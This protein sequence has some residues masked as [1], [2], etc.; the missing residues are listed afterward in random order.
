MLVRVKVALRRNEDRTEFNQVKTFDFIGIE[1]G[2]AFAP[3]AKDVSYA[4]LTFD[5]AEIEGRTAA[6][7][8]K[9][10]E[11]RA[12]SATPSSNGEAHK[13]GGHEP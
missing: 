13:E 7:G 12:T 2:D 8:E 6:T 10:A 1:K 3:D 11:P 9:T 4:D 5:V